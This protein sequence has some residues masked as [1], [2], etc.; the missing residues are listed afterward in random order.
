MSVSDWTDLMPETVYHAEFASRDDYG[1]PV[2][3]SQV[4]YSARVI[5]KP[6]MVK[7][8]DGKDIVAKGRVWIAGTPSVT[9]QDEIE[10]PDGTTPPI[11]NV[12]RFSDENGAHHVVIDFG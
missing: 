5:Y 12:G 11:L 6:R 9:P 4:G 3:G 1:K 10:L 7:A 2:Y 8:A